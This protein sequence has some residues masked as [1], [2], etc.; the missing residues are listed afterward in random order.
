M[1]IFGQILSKNTLI[2][3]KKLLKMTIVC[4]KCAPW[5]SNQEWRSICVDTV[6]KM[7]TH[8]A[9]KNNRSGSRGT[10][11]QSNNLVKAFFIRCLIL[12]NWDTKSFDFVKLKKVLSKLISLVLKMYCKIRPL[13]L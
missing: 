2:L 11:E 8:L 1:V 5:R 3:D 9:V 13:F 6:T 10:L 4:P 12:I 7:E